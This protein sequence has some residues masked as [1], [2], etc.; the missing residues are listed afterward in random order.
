MSD[1]LDQLRNRIAA[2]HLGD[3][4]LGPRL[5]GG[6]AEQLR[7]DAEQL[8]A[9]AGLPDRCGRPSMAAEL[10]LYRRRRRRRGGN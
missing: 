6:N 7:E 4:A 10:W 1:G 5:H 3:A 9:A 2:E 8:R